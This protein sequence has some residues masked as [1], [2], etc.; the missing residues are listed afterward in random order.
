VT[1]RL[2]ALVLLLAAAATEA[3]DQPLRSLCIRSAHATQR[4]RRGKLEGMTVSVRVETDGFEG[5]RVRAE[6]QLTA[7]DDKRI[8]VQRGTPA[9]Y[10]DEHGRVR[11]AEAKRVAGESACET[12]FELFIPY[13]AIIPPGRRERRVIVFIIVRCGGLSGLAVFGG[14]LPPM[15]P[16]PAAPGL[17]FEEVALKHEQDGFAVIIRLDSGALRRGEIRAGI[18]LR[19][20]DGKAVRVRANAPPDLTGPRGMFDCRGKWDMDP[21]GASA[22]PVRLF[23]PYD[24]LDLPPGREH[25]LVL[26]AYAQVGG[27][28]AI[29]EQE[30]RLRIGEATRP[31][32]IPPAKTDGPPKRDDPPPPKRDDPPPPKRKDPPPPKRKD[33]PKAEVELKVAHPLANEL[34][35]PYQGHAGSYGLDSNL[36]RLEAKATGLE[37]GLH[38]LQVDLGAGGRRYVWARAGAESGEASFSA[39]LPIPCGPFKATLSLP[40]LDAKGAATLEGEMAPHAWAPSEGELEEW[41]NALGEWRSRRVADDADSSDLVSSTLV[42]MA[43]GYLLR[44]DYDRAEQACEDCLELCTDP[45]GNAERR[46]EIDRIRLAL[47]LLRGELPALD[48]LCRDWVEREKQADRRAALYR[49]WAE[50]RAI[51]DPDPCRAR[52][53]WRKAEQAAKKAGV[54]RPPPPAWFE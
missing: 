36:L 12:S 8:R 31:D 5:S 7:P 44:G 38:C 40:G 49:E 1:A 42:Q 19:T 18:R 30:I 43:G 51:L 10:R 11:V 28:R 20:P 52:D 46:Y 29:G 16:P 22:V 17:R 41:R 25:S 2:A 34:S 9:R 54:E 45:D 27:W 48:A 3:Q 6:V 4:T 26:A 32:V 47:H 21:K 39:A 37:A 35:D 13:G 24:V 15:R 33:P 53:L 23:V 50:R 14:F